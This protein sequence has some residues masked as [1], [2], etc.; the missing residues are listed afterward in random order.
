MGGTHGDP[1]V[2]IGITDTWLDV[3]NP[4]FA[5][6]I[7][8]LGPNTPHVPIEHGTLVAGRAAGATDNGTGYPAIG[9]NCRIDFSS[10]YD[11]DNEMRRLSVDYGRK[12][13]TGSWFWAASNDYSATTISSVIGSQIIYNEIY[14]NG[15]I[16]CIAAG[17]GEGS[18][19]PASYYLFPA[20]LDHVISTTRVMG[21]NCP[22]VTT[23]ACGT[24]C[25]CDQHN[26]ITG[27]TS[28]YAFQH[29][30][31]VDICAPAVRVGGTDYNTS[32]PTT[33]DEHY[34]CHDCG[35]GTSFASP[36]TAGTLALMLAD[37]PCLSPYQ[38]EYALKMG[39]RNIYGVADNA[40]VATPPRL[41]AGALDAGASIVGNGTTFGG[42]ISMNCNDPATQSFFIDGIE[43]NTI[44][45][46]GLSSNGVNPKLVP[47]M[48]NGTPPYIYRWDPIP[49]NTTTLDD[50]T[51]ATPTIIASTGTNLAYYLLTVYDNSPVQKV[52]TRTISIQLQTSLTPT[53]GMRDS[54]LDMLDQPN[55][56]ATVDP[57][58]WNIW[59]SPDLW[60]RQNPDGVT[61]PQNI[62]YNSGDPN[63]MYFR[64]RNVGCADYTPRIV[65]PPSVYLYWTLG[66]TGENWPG[67][68]TTTMVAGAGGGVVPAG[69][70]ITGSYGIVVPLMHPGDQFISYQPWYPVNCANYLGSPTSV[71]E[72]GLARLDGWQSTTEVAHTSDNVRN[73]NTIV[74]R[75]MTAVTLDPANLPPTP[76]THQIYVGN[77]EPFAQTF[78]L[79]MIVDRD[80]YKYFAG[81]LSEYMYVKVKLQDSLFMAWQN[82]GAIGNY[83]SIDQNDS[84]I[85]YDPS[86][87][88]RLNSI[89]L[90]SG[91]KYYVQISFI[92][93]DGVTVTVPAHMKMHFRQLINNGVSDQVYGDYSFAVKVVAPPATCPGVLT[94]TE[95]SNGPTPAQAA[96]GQTVPVSG[97]NYGELLVSGCGQC[98][99]PTVNVEG[100]IIDDN[101]GNFNLNGCTIFGGITQSHYMLS[102]DSIW[103][104]V[105]VGSMIVVYNADSN[106]YNLPDTFTITQGQG[107]NGDKASFGNTYWVP[108]GGTEANPLGKPHMKRF[109]YTLDSSLCNYVVDTITTADTTYDSSYYALA[110]DWQNTINFDPNGDAFQVRCPRCGGMANEPDF[111]HGFGYGS[112][113]GDNQFNNIPP[114]SSSP[115]GAVVNDTGRGHKYCFMGSGAADLGDPSQWYTYSA[116]APGSI[117]PTLGN[118]NTPYATA[119]Q[120][121]ALN[122]PCCERR[123]HHRDDD[124]HNKNGGSS[125]NKNNNG[126]ANQL[127]R[128]AALQSL[129]SL[130]VYPIPATMTLNFRYSLQDNTTI[131][132]FDVTGRI[133]DTQVL[134]SSTSASF[135]VEGYTPGIYMYQ[136]ITD[137]NTQSG[138]VLI[139]K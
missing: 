29:N 6:K 12:I 79:Q 135:N 51:A 139:G 39:A 31:R 89:S 50:P 19:Y 4:D 107:V 17:N 110:S 78:S 119:A 58:E 67:D 1:S 65:S 76:A 61:I 59:L 112:D 45:A 43:F 103:A 37:K 10:N 62:E 28:Y 98:S 134:Q 113:S 106:C 7:A 120:Q 35:W 14:E 46:P 93:R 115:G 105:P 82:G 66:S 16:T 11:D 68:W 100:W 25:D 81:N 64:V 60:N 138:K 73:Y 122:L 20:S 91:A 86:A 77:T 41:G 56:Q 34:F 126:L 101:S 24:P 32:Y 117:P 49:D 124:R 69:G 108:L 13:L 129:Q 63:Y 85:Y 23:A 42:V 48:H 87:P 53:I 22:W 83:A 72:C 95:L 44:C 94:V 74:T 88:L 70:Q 18:G 132:L 3:T 40:Y 116:D 137:N 36:Q 125:N 33:D 27:D 54:Y 5:Y 131:K 9:F 99:S 38:L 102:Y 104:N 47:I 57:W 52:A 8:R 121:G 15:T 84:S 136:V 114:D 80:I 133:M 127:R 118:V 130:S 111:Y 26:Y 96:P 123:H 2:V 71:E 90:D 21:E 75:N 92:L 128:Q 97:C 30:P 55:S 109:Q